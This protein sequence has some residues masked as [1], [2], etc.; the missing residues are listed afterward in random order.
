MLVRFFGRQFGCFK[1][2]FDLSLVAADLKRVEDRNREL[3]P[4]SYNDGHVPRLR[5][6]ALCL[7]ILAVRPLCL[8][9][10]RF[11]GEPDHD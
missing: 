3:K 2:D 6:R 5:N 7:G 1:E 8:S 9:V 10:H 4:D 11:R